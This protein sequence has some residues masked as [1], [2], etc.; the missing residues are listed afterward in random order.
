MSI[1]SFSKGNTERPS[2]KSCNYVIPTDSLKEY[3]FSQ[4]F[5]KTRHLQSVFVLANSKG[6]TKSKNKKPSSSCYITCFLFTCE[7]WCLLKCLLAVFCSPLHSQLIYVLSIS[8]FH[9]IK[10][11]QSGET[12]YCHIFYKY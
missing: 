2:R 12:I 9:P 8:C 5:A 10:K 11:N 3:P 4:N 7:N 6:C 1:S